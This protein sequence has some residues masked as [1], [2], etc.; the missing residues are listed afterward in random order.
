MLQNKRKQG[1]LAVFR[2]QFIENVAM[3]GKKRESSK[4]KNEETAQLIKNK[5]LGVQQNKKISFA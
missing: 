2:K 3:S 1:S 4:K 5:F